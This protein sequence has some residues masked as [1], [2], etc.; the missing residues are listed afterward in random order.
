MGGKSKSKSKQESV[1]GPSTQQTIASNL[2]LEAIRPGSTGLGGYLT[3]GDTVSPE[4]VT[5]LQNPRAVGQVAA[6]ITTR[7]TDASK[8]G[9]GVAQGRDIL[10][11]Y[12]D[13]GAP[14]QSVLPGETA[15]GGV[16]APDTRAIDTSQT[17]STLLPSFDDAKYTD[18]FEKYDAGQLSTSAQAIVDSVMPIVENPISAS[19]EQMNE[20]FEM[21]GA[22]EALTLP[23]PT[24]L[25]SVVTE[26]MQD[27]PAPMVTFIDNVLGA[28]TD[29]AIAQELDT[30]STE[31][32]AIGQDQA[33]DMMDAT[34][35]QMA[36][37]GIASSGA[38][39]AAIQDGLVDIA[40]N[41]NAQIAQ[42]RVEALGTLTQARGLGVN[43]I[44]DLF[45]RGEQQQA[46]ELS[47]ELK[48]LEVEAA[49]QAA[50][51]Q[52]HTQVQMQLNQAQQNAMALVID[53]QRQ[54]EANKERTQQFI[55]N[56][57]GQLA[58]AGPASTYQ[59]GKSKSS[60]F[61]F[62]G[63]LGMTVSAESIFGGSDRRLKEDISL[64]GQSPS[65]INIY[66]FKYKNQ[67][68]YYQGVMADEVPHASTMVNGYAVVNYSLVDVDFVKLGE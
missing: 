10:K 61:N 5:E 1:T 13:A 41:Y 66:K 53:E 22:N 12:L 21:A 62:G 46:M 19:K 4:T 47:R 50:K 23:D 2:L 16:R 38:A 64:I 57:L 58:T 18:F 30:L 33:K 42:A 44:S 48:L 25:T 20:I 32:M 49:K 14:Y 3:T 68:G 15:A 59:Y 29:A 54:I 6:P 63:S 60:S 39:L 45:Q 37:Q 51:I 34:L 26:I 56:L 11:S 36:Q 27:S 35:G 67:D 8:E 7:Q 28:G 31:L 40:K 65:G 17:Y 9:Y 24:P 43:I 55:F 52:A